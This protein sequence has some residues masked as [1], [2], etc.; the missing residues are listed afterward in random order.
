MNLR[1][2]S[3][4]QSSPE[5]NLTAVMLGK[6]QYAAAFVLRKLE[7]PVISMGERRSP[8]ESQ[9]YFPLGFVCQR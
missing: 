6:K 2:V 4:L 7:K 9:K 5:M 3:V 1:C 8:G